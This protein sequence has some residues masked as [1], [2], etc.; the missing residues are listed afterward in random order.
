MSLKGVLAERQEPGSKPLSLFFKGLQ[1]THLFVDVDQR[2]FGLL[3]SV[4]K[5]CSGRRARARPERCSGFL[6]AGPHLRD[7][8]CSLASACRSR[9]SG[10]R[11]RVDS[12][13]R[14]ATVRSPVIACPQRFI[15]DAPEYPFPAKRQV[16]A[17]PEGQASS[18]GGRLA[19]QA[20]ERT[21]PAMEGRLRPFCRWPPHRPETG[22]NR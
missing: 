16:C 20:L 18:R 17:A 7:P 19:R 13:T 22:D 1:S 9:R 21:V 8:A 4:F 5:L 6:L 14:V 2:V 3:S 11:P 12:K 10:G 15:D